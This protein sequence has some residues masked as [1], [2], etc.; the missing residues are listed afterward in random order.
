[1]SQRAA[2]RRGPGSRGGIGGGLSCPQHPL[3]DQRLERCARCDRENC[4]DCLVFLRGWPLCPGCKYEHV[5]DLLSGLVPGALDMASVGRRLAGLWIDNLITTMA[6]YAFMIPMFMAVGVMASQGGPDEPPIWIM[7]VMYPLIFGVPLVYEGFMLQRRG[8]TLGKMAMGTKVVTADGS[9]IS[10]RQAWGRAA[11][12]LV[13]GSCM[14]V[15]FLPALFTHERTCLHD[16][17]A[18]TRVV[19]VQ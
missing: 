19:R 1:M 11:L 8:Q 2:M 17:I 12:K 7:A 13:L 4:P 14:G 16:M 3:V 15:D 6:A 5:R 10:G 9:D 18:K